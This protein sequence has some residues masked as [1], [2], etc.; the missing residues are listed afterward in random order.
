MIVSL[1]NNESATLREYAELSEKAA[2]R[3]RVALRAA[4][5]Q[6]GS[7]A[8]DG[9][10]EADPRTWGM[11]KDLQGESTAIEVYQDRCIVEMVKQWTLGDLPTMETAGD[12]PAQTYAL[13]AIKATEAASP[14]DDFT[15]DGAKDPKAAIGDSADSAATSSA[16]VSNHLTPIC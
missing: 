5:E 8:A 10:D 2:R 7:L 4:L 9:F 11:L 3:I 6:A 15:V 1:P 16:V 13:L 12:L 14:S